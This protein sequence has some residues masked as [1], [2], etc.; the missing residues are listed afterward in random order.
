MA[1]NSILNTMVLL[2]KGYN[3]IMKKQRNS[4]LWPMFPPEAQGMFWLQDKSRHRTLIK[5]YT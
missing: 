4:G 1:D 3:L 2:S 5:L